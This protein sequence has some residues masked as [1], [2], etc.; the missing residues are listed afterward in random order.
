MEKREIHGALRCLVD[1]GTKR[2]NSTAW[3]SKFILK[4][5]GKVKG[6]EEYNIK[7]RKEFKVQKL[8]SGLNHK[9]ISQLL[10]YFED[11][12]RIFSVSEGIEEKDILDFLADY[13]SKF[14]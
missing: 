9:N 11:D 7:L 12:F 1:R 10:H 6:N 5:V 14:G 8:L 3:N 4:R 13:V 2:V